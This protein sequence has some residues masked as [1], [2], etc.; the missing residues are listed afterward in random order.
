MKTDLDQSRTVPFLSQQD[1]QSSSHLQLN[2]S[3]YANLQKQKRRL[4]IQSS[5]QNLG[6]QRDTTTNT[7]RVP[8]HYRA[9]ETIIHYNFNLF[10]NID[11][12]TNEQKQD[13][14]YEENS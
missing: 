1:G 5:L 2:D 14:Q 10:E 11:I 3:F 6:R 13:S 9:P 4:C 7:P 8:L 12:S